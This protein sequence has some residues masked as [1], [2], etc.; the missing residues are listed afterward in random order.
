M[1]DVANRELI[2]SDLEI[3]TSYSERH[4]DISPVVPDRCGV[5]RIDVGRGEPAKGAGG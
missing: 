4:E 5:E 2:C 3:M 1:S